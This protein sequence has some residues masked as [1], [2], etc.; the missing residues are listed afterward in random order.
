MF[1]IAA[2][3]LSCFTFMTFESAVNSRLSRCMFSW[4]CRYCRLNVR[5]SCCSARVASSTS[6]SEDEPA[7][8]AAPSPVAPGV[9][10][11]DA[12]PTADLTAPERTVPAGTYGA[13]SSTVAA[14][15]L[16]RPDA[17]LRSAFSKRPGSA[18]RSVVG[19][20]W[21]DSILFM[22]PPR[23]GASN[24]RA[25]GAP[26]RRACDRARGG[27]GPRPG[28]VRADRLADRA[29]TR[30]RSSRLEF[31]REVLRFPRAEGVPPQALRRD[32]P[33]AEA[34]PRAARHQLGSPRPRAVLQGRRAGAP[35]PRVPAPRLL[36]QG[37]AAR[38][39]RAAQADPRPESHRGAAPPPLR[40]VHGH[41]GDALR[42]RDAPLLRAVAPDLRRPA[43]PL[44]RPQR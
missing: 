3:A 24:A 29:R 30:S 19:A 28:T 6:P 36:A 2:F 7:V 32:R 25:R 20:T 4:S 33:R 10:A 26:S 12:R 5:A 9:P 38:A 43:R 44:P 37:E 13:A 15:P 42:A 40:R 11:A 41:R 35:P 21:I 8:A 18:F 39:A 22:G 17:A 14:T 27:H 1:E 23:Q 34:D 31:S 16:A